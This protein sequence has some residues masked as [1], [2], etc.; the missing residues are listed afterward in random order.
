LYIPPVHGGFEV[1]DCLL[2]DE[3]AVGGEHKISKDGSV[4][5]GEDLNGPMAGLGLNTGSIPLDIPS[6]SSSRNG[7]EPNGHNDTLEESGEDDEEEESREHLDP[8]ERDWSEKWLNGVVR[9][10]QGW[11][12]ENE[13]DNHDEEGQVTWREME[14]VLKD[15]SAALAMMAGTS[16]MSPLLFAA[17][18][19]RP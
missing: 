15:A 9:R 8:F 12:E 3:D 6:S 5:H 16:G 19:R 14:G 1:S 13:S 18:Y 7:N 11:L 4:R 10:A 17:I 2:E